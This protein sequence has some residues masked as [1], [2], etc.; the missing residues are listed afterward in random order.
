MDEKEQK[1][2]RII[3]I[4]LIILGL[5]V[6][7]LGFAR[8]NNTIR[9]PINRLPSDNLSQAPTE[10]KADVEK[11]LELKKKDTDHDGLSDYDELNV[12]HTSIYI[13]DSDSD[14]YSDKQEVDAGE[15]PNCPRG[16]DC[17][18][19][20][21]SKQKSEENKTQKYNKID[22]SLNNFNDLNSNLNNNNTNEAEHQEINRIMSGGA[23]LDEVKQLLLKAG[24]Q[25]S[26]LAKISDE[27]IMGMYQDMV[28]KTK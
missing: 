8:L 10:D 9:R 6:L 21:V 3:E 14:G 16:K 19:P 17:S 13:A 11:I 2:S 12:Y 5:G 28:K 15:D 26:D 7:F 25:E 18:L 1:Q 20:E 23:T 22:K 4:F 24:M 27:D